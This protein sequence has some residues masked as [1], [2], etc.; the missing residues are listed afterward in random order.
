[1]KTKIDFK[2]TSYLQQ[3]NAKQRHA[4]QVLHRHKV[5]SILKD[6]NPVLI[7]TIPIEVDIESSD[8][9][10]ACHF[11]DRKA[12]ERV[13]K[14]AFSEKQGFQIWENTSSEPKATIA[15]FILEDFE[16][17]IFGQNLPTTQQRG[18]RHMLVEHRVLEKRG[19]H[20]RQRIIQLKNKG[21]K[22]EPSFAIAL[23][24]EGD[25]YEALLKLE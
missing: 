7:G 5:L 2:N 16:V 3:G 17:E 1:M 18:Y 25:P 20:F 6:F 19:E 24:L 10:I 4:Y 15:K 21:H 9:D 13:L 11:V 12:F 8:L 14:Q 23:G 22:T